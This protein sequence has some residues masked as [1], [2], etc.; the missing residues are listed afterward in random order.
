MS[1]KVHLLFVESRWLCSAGKGAV[2]CQQ[3][4]FI[5][6]SRRAALRPAESC[7][8]PR[9]FCKSA[10]DH[11]IHWRKL[12][13][14]K[15]MKSCRLI[16]VSL[17]SSFTWKCPKLELN[18]RYNLAL[19]PQQSLWRGLILHVRLPPPTP[20]PWRAP[21]AKRSGPGKL[22]HHKSLTKICKS[23]NLVLRLLRGSASCQGSKGN[24]LGKKGE[25][26]W[27]SGLI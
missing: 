21:L 26:C 12:I 11:P 20:A 2:P 7:A 9:L 3:Q 13:V 24:V 25:R 8:W 6:S 27:V 22:P 23:G 17:K 15:L 14:S 16:N 4:F 1:L 10:N 5:I 19:M 18:V